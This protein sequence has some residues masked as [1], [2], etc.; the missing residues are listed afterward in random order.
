MKRWAKK[1]LRW[2]PFA[3][4]G[5]WLAREA[6]HIHHH[7]LAPHTLVVCAIPAVAACVCWWCRRRKGGDE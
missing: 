1:V 6:T 7:L 4:A 3:I 2:S 5:G